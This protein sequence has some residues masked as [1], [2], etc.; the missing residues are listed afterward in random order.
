MDKINCMQ[1]MV[2]EYFGVHFEEKCGRCGNCINPVIS[3]AVDKTLH[4]KQLATC[5]Q[6]M[7]S[8]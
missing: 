8:S 4:A 6:N 3:V 5:L 7:Q 2:A 1:K